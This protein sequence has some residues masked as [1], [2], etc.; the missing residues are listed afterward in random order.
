M[1]QIDARMAAAILAALVFFGIAYNGWIAQMGRRK[2]GY[3]GLLVAAGVIVTLLGVALIDWRAAAL[4]LAAFVASGTP[5]LIG[6]ILR[7][8]QE[9]EEAAR[10]DRIRREIELETLRSEGRN[11]D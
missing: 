7:S 5:M 6:D 4:C 11:A 2:D 8:I 9:R 10:F 3:A 1:Q